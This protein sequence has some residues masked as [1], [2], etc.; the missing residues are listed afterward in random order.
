MGVLEWA[1][2]EANRRILD[3]LRE[4]LVEGIPVVC[5]Q[6]QTVYEAHSVNSRYCSPRCRMA[7][8]LADHPRERATKDGD[9]R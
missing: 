8:H 6:C 1:T 3:R 4:R 9:H 7:A 2:P 5:A